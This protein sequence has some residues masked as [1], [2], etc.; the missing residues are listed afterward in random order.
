M[1]EKKESYTNGNNCI[2]RQPILNKRKQTYGYELLF[3]D[4]LEE[5]FHHYDGN[6]A[7]SQV[8]NLTFFDAAI[9]HI[10][11]GRKAFINFTRFLLL[12]DFW[13]LLPKDQVVIEILENIDL[14]EKVINACKRLKQNGYLIA[15]DDYIYNPLHKPILPY[16]DIIKVDFSLTPAAKFDLKPIQEQNKKT[17]FLA[18][19]VEVNDEFELSLEK[20][21]SL[22]QGYFFEKPDLIKLH[23]TNEQCLS[24]IQLLRAVCNKQFDLQDAEIIFKHDPLLTYKLLRYINSAAIG[25]RYSIS[26]IS[27]ALAIIGQNNLRKWVLVLIMSKTSEKKADELIRQTVYRANFC[28]LLAGASGLA[29]D[30]A[31]L[32]ITGLF[33]S[34][35]AIL[36]DTLENLLNQIPLSREIVMA[37]TGV[38]TPYYY[39]LMLVLAFEKGTWSKVHSICETIRINEQL[40]PQM[41]I[42]SVH[43]ADSFT[44][45]C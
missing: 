11:S 23:S 35:E 7:T 36:D 18:E 39:I 6:Q 27:Q 1:P 24:T 10:I 32:F 40:L 37:L 22:F 15:L 14:D 42:S 17:I 31:E 13:K 33:S 30:A 2:A 43:F 21:Y 26:S 41:H 19:K 45:E 34:I 38:E 9:S 28:E 8:I 20:G 3:R 44:A 25:L 4:G 12:D 16:I 29:N 5:T